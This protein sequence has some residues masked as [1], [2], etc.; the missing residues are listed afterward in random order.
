M[1]KSPKQ[2]LLVSGTMLVCTMLL[3]PCSCEIT[4]VGASLSTLMDMYHRAM[5]MHSFQTATNYQGL[6]GE[7][8][9]V[10][11]SSLVQARIWGLFLVGQ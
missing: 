11:E 4:S 10:Y 6:D 2:V 1:E 8:E 7:W 3:R 5:E 9:G